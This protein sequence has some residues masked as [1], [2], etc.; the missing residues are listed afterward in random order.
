MGLCRGSY[1][2]RPANEKDEPVQEALRTL[3]GRH[4]GWGFWKLHHRLRKNGLSINHKRTWRIYR[5]MGLHLP[6]RLKKRLPARVKQP[7]A[8]P[9]AA[10]GCWSLDFTSDV[11]TDSR[12]FRTLNVFDDYNRQLLGVEIDFSLP[13]ARV[14]QVLARLVE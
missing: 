12:W 5:A 6:R 4:P 11:L 9:E 7:L 13:A 8:V 3:S 1:A 2:T 10:N 14:V